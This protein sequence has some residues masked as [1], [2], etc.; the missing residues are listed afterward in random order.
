MQLHDLRDK[1][2]TLPRHEVAMQARMAEER[3]QAIEEHGEPMTI[4]ELEGLAMVYGIDAELLA[5]D[6]SASLKSMGPTLLA[7]ENGYGGFTTQEKLAILQASRAVNDLTDLKRL[8]NAATE[9]ENPR[10]TWHRSSHQPWEQG[11]DIAVLLR[12]KL[13]LGQDPV[14]SLC[15]LVAEKWSWISILHADL[16]DRGPSGLS[17]SNQ[18]QS[19]TIVL[20]VSGKNQS[21]AVLRIS[22]AHELY[23]VLMDTSHSQPLAAFSRHD[24]LR[25]KMEQRANSFAV[26]FLCPESILLKELEEAKDGGHCAIKI[27]NDFGLPYA[28]VHQYLKNHGIDISGRDLDMSGEKL[29]RRWPPELP[30]SMRNFPLM[31]TP[32]ARRTVIAELAV[33]AY[34]DEKISRD[35]LAAL[36]GV[37][38]AADLEAVVRHVSPPDSREA[39]S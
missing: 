20:N 15:N 35:R 19:A 33:R 27:M 38:P 24:E 32:L 21:Q 29:S 28:A 4:A 14:P 30:D 10:L 7:R 22:F 13:S 11:R 6:Q 26:R 36:L 1:V 39:S 16:G 12:R 5:G 9:V 34:G 31:D 23:H 2:L 17:F 3:L 18:R 37:T 8:V 25:S